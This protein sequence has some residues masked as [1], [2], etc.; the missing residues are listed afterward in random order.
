MTDVMTLQ[1]LED[2]EIEIVTSKISDSNH[3]S[4]DELLDT[5]EEMLG[6]RRK[7]VHKTPE[8]EQEHH[9]HNHNHG[10]HHAHS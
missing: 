1:I 9:H 6:G 8:R 10:H 5:L 2:G 4:A 7:T 3:A